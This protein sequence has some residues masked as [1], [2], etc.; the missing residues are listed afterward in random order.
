VEVCEVDDGPDPA[1]AGGDCE[2]VVRGAEL[3]HATHD[4]HAE[5]DSAI[6]LLQPL[7]QLTELLDDRVDRRV[8]LAAEQEAGVEHD[9]FCAGGLG[10]ARRMVEHAHRHVELLAPLGMAHETRDRCVDREHDPGGPCE[11]TELLGPGV[12]H[13]ELPLEVDLAGREAA[14]LEELDRSLWAVP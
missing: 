6:L 1:R 9:D 5:R 12:V 2:D 10:N 13:P 7:P 11:L 4:L 14:L 8:A 3:A